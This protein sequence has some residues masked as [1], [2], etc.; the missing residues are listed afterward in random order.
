MHEGYLNDITMRASAH[1]KDCLPTQSG[2]LGICQ[3]LT[4]RQPSVTMKTDSQCPFSE[5]ICAGPTLRL[6][7]GPVDSL[8]DLGIN[9]DNSVS[10]RI[11]HEC[12]PLK[13]NSY[14]T[15]W[16]N[17]SD[18]RINFLQFDRPLSPAS[19]S[20]LLEYGQ[21]LRN[22]YELDGI[23]SNPT[24]FTYLYND[25]ATN[26]ANYST[27]GGIKEIPDFMLSWV[28]T[29]KLAQMIY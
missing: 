18:P 13:T 23:D 22:G 3:P 2:R 7:S 28:F 9:S 26:A 14:R 6:D 4:R 10:V 12:V 19:R 20:L 24:N 16:L 21:G 17:L 15:D 27:V 8:L 5:D 25:Y 29:I 1:A 11:V